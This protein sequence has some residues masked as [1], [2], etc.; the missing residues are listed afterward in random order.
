MTAN[1]IHPADLERSLQA[2]VQAAHARAREPRSPRRGAPRTRLVR[3]AVAVA[4]VASIVAATVAFADGGTLN[5]QVADRTGYAVDTTTDGAIVEYIGDKNVSFGSAG[6]GQFGTFLQTQDDPSEEGYNTDGVTEFDT[7]SSPQFNR[8]ILLSEIPIVPCESLDGN[9]TTPGLC[10]EL[11]A[12]INDSNAQDPSAVQIQL[13]DLEIWLTD[14]DEITGY[15]QGG[16]GFGTDA[17]LVY[18]FDGTMLVN[19]VN[20]GS[21]RGDL[22][23]LIPLDE[24]LAPPP[25]ECFLGSTTCETFFVVYTEWGDP[26]DGAFKS[27]SGFEEWKVR[28]IDFATKSGMKFNDLDADGVKDAGEP[29]L[30]GWTIYVDYNNNSVKDI[31][32]AFAVT[33]SDA[34]TLG[35]YT[36][37]GIIPGTWN[38]REVPQAGWVCSFPNAGTETAPV[39]STACL[40]DEAFEEGDELEGNDFGNWA[41]ATKEGRKFNDLNGDGDSESGIDPGL[42]GWTINI[43]ADD[44]DGVL[45]AAEFT[46]GAVGTD[47][48]DAGTG[49]YSISNLAPGDYIVCEVSQPDWVQTA[50]GGTD[51]CAGSGTL[52]AD[53]WAITLMS[54]QT[55]LGNDFGNFQLLDKTGSKY[56]DDEGDGSITG[57]S[58]YTGG[59]TINIY[60][61]D[62]DNTLDLGDT[63]TSTV[64]DGSGNYAFNNL[65]PGTYFVCEATVS[66]WIQTF[67]NTVG[68]E[69]IDTCDNIAG[70]AEF[71]YTFTAASGS[72]QTLNDFGNFQLLDKTGSKYVDDEG[73]GSI[74]GDSKYT[75]GWT[76]NIYRDDGDNTLDLGDTVT[77]TVTDGSGNYAFNNLGPGTYFVCEATVSDWIQTF[78]NTV[79][80]EVIDT[81]DNIAGN[82][83]FG[84]TFTAASGSD[85]TLNDFGNFQLLDKGGFKFQ[86]NDTDGIFEPAP[87]PQNDTKLSGWTI[88]LWKLVSGTWQWVA[89]DVTDAAGYSF[90]NLGPGTYAVCEISQTDWVQSFPFSG[91]TVP[92]SETVFDCTS[93]TPNSGGAFAPFGFR[94]TASSGTDQLSNN[95]GNFLVPPGCSLT[96]GYWKTHSIHGPAAHPDDTWNLITAAMTGAPGGDLGPDTQ[97][98][99]SGMTWYEVFWTNPKGGNAWYI[100][101]H[102]YMA[103]VLN[104]LNGAGSPAGLAAALADAYV[105][106]D[107]YDGTASIPKNGSQ[108]LTSAKD[109]DEA[110]QIAGF[111]AAYNEG[112]LPG[113]SHCGEASFAGFKT[114]PAASGLFW[115]FALAP[116]VRL[117]KRRR[118]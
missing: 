36:I 35:Q 16:A 63:V 109:R 26:E 48:T 81:C 2:R 84:Y 97:F 50:P 18:D 115:P 67:P 117:L 68:G 91:A 12:D 103:A 71:G 100:L 86:D 102:Q 58:K 73:D 41:T 24:L 112:T 47:V 25:V 107:H 101:A 69:V 45:S 20:Q 3:N 66:D 60:R 44:G 99:D 55:D 80:G 53:G 105:L 61:D 94:F 27:D 31:G 34:G 38:V 32:E 118:A 19:D 64:T 13:T 15:D 74:T 49:V 21:G 72:D 54:G 57:D 106:L 95:F 43:Y 83:E 85:Q 6:T 40:Y 29:G 56:V 11:F 110:I 17:D 23:Y 52:G 77:S 1:L 22:R 90:P 10:W 51:E 37:P 59:W 28:T 46:A 87:S 75:G 93:L 114:G 9:E 65:G 92:A 33:S 89:T 113:T 30:G 96:Q 62:G 108:V 7:G 4:A 116:I 39:T 79:G 111:L 42:G 78:P 70:N 14:D 8:A 88:E 82:A 5:L 98:F 104:Q 76:I